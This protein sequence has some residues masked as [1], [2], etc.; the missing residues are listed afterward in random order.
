MDTLQSSTRIFLMFVGSRLTQYTNSQ[1]RANVSIGYT[2]IAMSGDQT[3]ERQRNSQTVE[4]PHRQNPLLGIPKLH[5]TN[6]QNTATYIYI[7]IWIIYRYLSCTGT[8]P[9]TTSAI[10]MATAHS[11]SSVM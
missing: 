6:C 5:I 4:P 7:I 9:A 2:N 10:T 3:H 11:N 8:D 1:T